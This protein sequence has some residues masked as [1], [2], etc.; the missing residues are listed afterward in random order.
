MADVDTDTDTSTLSRV[1]T[2]PY[3]L[4][5]GI[6]LI[7]FLL[8]TQTNFF[9]AASQILGALGGL[10]LTALRALNKG[11]NFLLSHPWLILGAVIGF[12]I[13]KSGLGGLTGMSEEDM[14]KGA[15]TAVEA[16][17]SGASETAAA[18]LGAMEAKSSQY[19]EEDKAPEAREIF[20]KAKEAS[21]NYDPN[22]PEGN[23]EVD[24]EINDYAE[25]F[26]GAE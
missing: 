14:Q 9:K 17:E 25:D 20:E 21:E 6:L 23:A 24:D 26:E 8:L 10:L 4:G 19:E 1:F 3:V 18:N 5:G 11:L 16:E 12:F 15:D 2:N 22:D 7:G 13:V